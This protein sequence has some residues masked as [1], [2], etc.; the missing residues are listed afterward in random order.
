MPLDPWTDPDPQPGGALFEDEV[1]G[2][3][4]HPGERPRK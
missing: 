1:E 2:R 3:L 4:H